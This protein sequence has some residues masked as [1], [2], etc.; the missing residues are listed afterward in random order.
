MKDDGGVAKWRIVPSEKS[1]EDVAKCAFVARRTGSSKLF[2]Y[3]GFATAGKNIMYIVPKQ[4]RNFPIQF[5]AI[6]F[7]SE[8]CKVLAWHALRVPPR[9]YVSFERSS[10]RMQLVECCS[11]DVNKNHGIFSCLIWV[12]MLLAKQSLSKEFQSIFIVIEMYVK[13]CKI[14]L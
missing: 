11:Q 1:R 10:T 8:S 14:L 13:V 4:Q 3:H 12:K 7:R 6:S 9:S 5:P 2:I